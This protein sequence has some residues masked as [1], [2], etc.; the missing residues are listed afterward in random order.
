MQ[1]KPEMLILDVNSNA[2]SEDTSDML[3]GL[4]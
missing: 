1:T 4:L 3:L 2:K